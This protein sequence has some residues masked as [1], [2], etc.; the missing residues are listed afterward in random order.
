ML[1]ASYGRLG[2]FVYFD[3]YG[4]D[5][6][7][8]FERSDRQHHNL[9]KPFPMPIFA[10]TDRL[11]FP[12]PH[13]ATKEGLLAVGGDLG[14]QRLLL[15]YREGIFPWFSD[16]EPILWWSPDPRLVLYPNE[17]HLSASLKKRIRQ[18][19]FRLSAD[20]AFDAV[21]AECRRV[22]RK[23]QE[24]TWIV[25][26]MVDAYQ[27]LH[28]NGFAHSIEAWQDR[29]LV[30]GLYGVSL[31]R[32][33]FGESMFSRV[34]DASK[35]AL[36]GLVQFLAVLGFKLIDCQVPTAHLATLGAREIPRR[37]FLSE[38]EKALKKKTVAGSWTGLYDRLA[39]EHHLPTPAWPPCT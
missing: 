10:L 32:C 18:H 16:G 30:G 4:L 35:I 29:Q 39:D 22:P 24:G 19:R 23:H 36:A 38:L 34:S 1:I 14:Q 21:I 8:R 6:F 25:A 28:R 2:F 13:L 3:P 27:R 31:G 5:G 12:P 11:Q 9:F 15:A 7:D 26:S 33:F 17:M 37:R 20:R